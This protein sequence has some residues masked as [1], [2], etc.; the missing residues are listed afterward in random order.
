MELITRDIPHFDGYY[1]MRSDGVVFSNERIVEHAIHGQMKIKGKM[2][3]TAKYKNKHGT[4]KPANYRLRL[5]GKGH[6]V[7]LEFLKAITFPEIFNQ[8][9]DDLDGEVW[10]PL[11]ANNDYSVSNLGRVKRNKESFVCCGIEW[12]RADYLISTH[13]VSHKTS[14]YVLFGCWVGGS[15]TNLILGRSIYQ[16]F[17]RLLKDNEVIAHKDGC[18]ENNTLSNLIVRPKNSH[19]IEYWGAQ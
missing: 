8:S 7:G 10:K 16:S 12:V 3:S 11:Y 15:Q 17:V 14:Q 19:L 6:S 2:L 1:S 9:I 13:I 18:F 4:P 5:G